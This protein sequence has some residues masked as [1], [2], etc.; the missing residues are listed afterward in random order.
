[1]P[2]NL[3]AVQAIEGQFHRQTRAENGQENGQEK[4]CVHVVGLLRKRART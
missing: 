1:M 3:P 4:G 2:Q